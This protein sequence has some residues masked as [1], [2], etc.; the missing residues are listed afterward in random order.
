MGNAVPFPMVFWSSLSSK[1]LGN[2]GRWRSHKSSR[3][4]CWP[5]QARPRT[6]L[7]LDA[8][9]TR[10]A[11]MRKRAKLR[12]AQ[13][14]NQNIQ[15]LRENFFSWSHFQTLLTIIFGVQDWFLMEAVENDSGQNVRVRSFDWITIQCTFFSARPQPNLEGGKNKYSVL[16]RSGHAPFRWTWPN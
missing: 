1:L 13:N 3:D 8:M 4:K 2:P 16:L 11:T 14:Q 12:R 6:W 9:Q 15:V 7:A 10:T 5:A